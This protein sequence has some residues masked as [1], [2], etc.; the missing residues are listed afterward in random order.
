MERNQKPSCIH[1]SILPHHTPVADD[2]IR[3]MKESAAEV[4]VSLF[5]YLMVLKANFSN[6]SAIRWRAK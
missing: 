5:V 4:K 3:D 1:C 2:L 6:I